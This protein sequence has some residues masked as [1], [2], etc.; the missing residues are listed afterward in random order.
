MELLTVTLKPC[1]FC[2][3]EEPLFAQTIDHDWWVS[4]RNDECKGNVGYFPTSEEAVLA[5]NYRAQVPA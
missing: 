2:G 5:W 3:D 1:P 4:C